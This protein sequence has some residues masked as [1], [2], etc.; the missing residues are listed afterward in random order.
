METMKLGVVVAVEGDIAEIAMYSMANDSVILWNGELLNGPRVGSYITIL[1]GNVKIITKVISEKIIDQQNTIKS[2]EFDNRFSKNSINRIIKVKTTGVVKGDRFEITTKYIPMIGDIASITNGE[3][4]GVIYS[5]SDDPAET[6]IVGESIFGNYTIQLP[7]N[8]FFASHI[9]IF[10]NTG[11]GKSNTLHKIY[12]ELF[13][14]SCGVLQ[15]SKFVVIDFNGEYAHSES[16]GCKESQKCI[17]NI[18]TRYSSRNSDKIPISQEYLYD[19]E[20]LSIL[21]DARPATQVP[22]LRKS[23]NKYNEIMKDN[24]TYGDLKYGKYIL[25]TLKK[26]LVSRKSANDNAFDNWLET[27]YK[28]NEL[29]GLGQKSNLYGKLSSIKPRGNDSYSIENTATGVDFFNS[30]GSSESVEL[31]FEEE[32]VSSLRNILSTIND[33]QKIG[34]ILEF[35]K[36]HST[37]W[38]KVNSE[39]LSPLFSRVSSSLKSLEKVIEIVE[40]P[41]DNIKP[42]TI[43][44]LLHV[45]QDI[46]RLIPMMFSKMIYD[47]QKYKVSKCSECVASTVH[48]IIDEAH[49]ILND[50]QQR[51]G[52]SWQDYR[53][54]LFEEIIKEGRK[55][56]F[57]LTL[58]S[59]RPA[60]ISETIL[61]QVHNYFIHRLVNERD[62]RM[63]ENTMPTLDAQSYKT[64]PSLGQGECIITG[65]AVAVPIFTKINW[66]EEDPRPKSDD[67]V[68]TD[69]WNN[70]SSSAPDSDDIFDL[71]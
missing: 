47:A 66:Q 12:M 1:Q 67:V 29:A 6:I 50:S 37:A 44:N 36:V 35:A 42:I 54:F 60:D 32:L 61:S 5:T 51:N 8:K 56:G 15:K 39:Y 26:I 71:L 62:L 27:Y 43:I 13:N 23:I 11:S 34:M 24:G 20:I 21:F 4:I 55:F 19:P 22:F 2:N 38:G 64:I 40:N 18:S 41:I 45:N 57:Y 69:I 46:K 9:G 10:G 7:V 16:F 3:E 70:H 28:Y 58:S 25:G 65:N 49:N 53:L 30:G 17:Y 14:F 52:D 48:L 68:L 31:E 33:I 59:Q 63:L